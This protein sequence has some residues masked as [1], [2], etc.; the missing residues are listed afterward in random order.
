MKESSPAA[1]EKAGLEWAA[2]EKCVKTDGAALHRKYGE[3]T[4]QQKDLVVCFV[5]FSF[6]F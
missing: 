2:V 5:K 4:H 1:A 3:L 6:A